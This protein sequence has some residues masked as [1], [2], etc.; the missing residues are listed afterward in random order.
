MNRW[1]IISLLRLFVEQVATGDPFKHKNFN[2]VFS[3]IWKIGAGRLEVTWKNGQELIDLTCFPH[4][5]YNI[6]FNKEH[7]ALRK[8]SFAL[9]SPPVDKFYRNDLCRYRLLL[10]GLDSKLLRFLL[11]QNCAREIRTYSDVVLTL[12]QVKYLRE[13]RSDTMIVQWKD[14]RP[15]CSS[16]D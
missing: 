12:W 14:L 16:L 11:T 2:F 9:A 15:A 13:P 7:N 3:I 1:P 8:E 10:Y 4:V 6:K 5:G